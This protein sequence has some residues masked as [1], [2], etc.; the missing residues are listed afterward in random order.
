MGSIENPILYI[1][2]FG[3]AP[4]LTHRRRAPDAAM[5]YRLP[6]GE[7]WHPPGGMTAGELLW[8]KPR[9]VYL[10]DVQPH[11]VD[12]DCVVRFGHG[13]DLA[14]VRFAAVWQ[15]ADPVA[16]VTNRLTQPLSLAGLATVS[17][18]GSSLDTAAAD[19]VAGVFHAVSGILPHRLEVAGGL[20]V[21]LAGLRSVSRGNPDGSSNITV[22]EAILG[23]DPRQV[24]REDY[25]LAQRALV[26]FP[27]SPEWTHGAP[28][29][30]PTPEV[31]ALLRAALERYGVLVDRL[32]EMMP[33]DGGAEL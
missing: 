30:G 25:D 28:A 10:V 3:A 6:D 16:A 12:I 13:D 15:V 14:G 7:L 27:D 2:E 11:V 32:G 24:W 20:R 1:E 23:S 26:S 31:I 21:D 4:D 17:W 8:R 22:L 5:V 9:E 29:D 18:L 19:T 33:F